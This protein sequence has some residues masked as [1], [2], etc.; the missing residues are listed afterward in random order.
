[1]T[2]T[3]LRNSENIIWFIEG[4]YFDHRSTELANSKN[5]QESAVVAL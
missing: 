3:F 1:M 5:A 2:S 4:S